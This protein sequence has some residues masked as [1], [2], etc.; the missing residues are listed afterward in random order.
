LYITLRV[1]KHF[2]H[3]LPPKHHLLHRWL[4]SMVAQLFSV[5]Q[6]SYADQTACELSRPV[7]LGA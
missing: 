2:L 1:T 5:Q 6:L 4:D 7:L 3:S